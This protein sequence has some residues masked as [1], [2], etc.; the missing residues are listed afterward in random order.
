MRRAGQASVSVPNSSLFIMSCHWS[1][2]SG[3]NPVSAHL[4][5]YSKHTASQ[6]LPDQPVYQRTA[7]VGLREGAALGLLGDAEGDSD[8]EALG[9]A[10][11]NPV[12]GAG[13]GESDGDTVGAVEGALVGLVGLLV[14]RGEGTGDGLAVG[15]VGSA[16]GVAPKHGHARQS[17]MLENFDSNPNVASTPGGVSS[18]A[19]SMSASHDA[20]LL[21]LH[22]HIRVGEWTNLL[23]GYWVQ[24]ASVPHDLGF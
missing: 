22:P 18:V 2:D 10:L 6:F 3:Q 7:V 14:G 20:L 4:P 16:V 12:D 15:T 24:L 21:R 1:A 5:P 9:E 11:G 17:T 19:S 13:V 23:A 8:G